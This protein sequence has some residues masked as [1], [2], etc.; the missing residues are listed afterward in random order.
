MF[1]SKKRKDRS[2]TK[3]EIKEEEENLIKKIII[4]KMDI[5]G[6][7]QKPKYTD[8]LWVQVILFPYYVSRYWYN[9]LIEISTFFEKLFANEL[10]VVKYTVK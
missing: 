5:R 2:K 9:S 3:E 6:S 1:F 7:Y 8:V 10:H 4:E